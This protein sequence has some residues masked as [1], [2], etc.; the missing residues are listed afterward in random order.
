MDKPY[1]STCKKC[2][3]EFAWHNRYKKHCQ[4][5]DPYKKRKPRRKYSAKFKRTTALIRQ[6]DKHTC[7][8]CKKSVVTN[9]AADVQ[10]PVHHIDGNEKN[11]DTKNLVTLCVPCHLLIHRQGLKKI[12]VKKIKIPRKI[13]YS[14]KREKEL[15]KGI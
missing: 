1:I 6:R 10:A 7:K 2:R 8:N 13:R 14:K 5:C 12:N 11:D 15:F 4:N 9:N 3:K